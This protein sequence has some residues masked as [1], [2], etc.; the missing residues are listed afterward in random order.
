MR[1]NDGGK[2]KDELILANAKLRWF[3]IDFTQESRESRPA[4]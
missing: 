1:K 2:L 3:F 4:P